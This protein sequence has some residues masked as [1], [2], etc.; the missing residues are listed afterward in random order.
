[1]KATR[2]NKHVCMPKTPDKV[3]HIS[4]FNYRSPRLTVW[5][6]ICPELPIAH[7]EINKNILGNYNQYNL[8]EIRSQNKP[9]HK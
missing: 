3:Q 1:M 8:P 6:N 4:L 2:A 7:K 5:V 9:T